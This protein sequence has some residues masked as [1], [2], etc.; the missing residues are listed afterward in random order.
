VSSGDWNSTKKSL[1]KLSRWLNDSVESGNEKQT[2]EATQA[3]LR[4]GGV[5]GA[6]KLMRKLY[7][8]KKL[9]KY[10]NT[11]RKLLAVNG[12]PSQ[13]ISDINNKNILKFDSGLTKIHA[14]H[15]ND[16]SP[17]Y[18]TRVAAAISLLY[19][20]YRENTSSSVKSILHFPCGKARGDQFRNPKDI[21]FKKSKAFYTEIDDHEWAQTQLRLGWI[22]WALLNKNQTLFSNEGGLAE[23]AHALEASLFVIGYDLRCFGVKPGRID[24]TKSLEKINRSNFNLVPTSHPFERVIREFLRLK[25]NIKQLDQADFIDQMKVGSSKLAYSTKKDYCFPLLGNEFDLF[26]ENK[27]SLALL[28]N[29]PYA[30]LELKFDNEGFSI[31]DERIYVCLQDCW[32]TGYLNRKFDPRKHSALLIQ[33]KFAGPAKPGK[34]PY[35]ANTI[36]YVGLGVGKYFNLLDDKGL[37]TRYFDKFFCQDMS[38]LESRVIDA[39]K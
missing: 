24:T 12:A 8:S 20:L 10:L 16:G 6:S 21:G 22:F 28:E 29:D 7:E 36:R 34:P 9:I 13:R 30:W 39:S 27:H 25:N 35:A 14:L 1:S 15:E 17:I 32:L 37:P 26:H 11:A 3:I 18:D 5:S 33:A 23:R 38:E 19:C 2:F 31:P 4:W